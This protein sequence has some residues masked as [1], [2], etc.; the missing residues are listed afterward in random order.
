[1]GSPTTPGQ[2]K[3]GLLGGSKDSVD[4]CNKEETTSMEQSNDETNVN[5]APKVIILIILSLFF[6]TMYIKHYFHTTQFLIA[7][8]ITDT[9]I[10]KAKVPK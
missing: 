3:A 6:I 2:N 10:K 4:N 1:M 8:L 7:L 5:G 9:Q